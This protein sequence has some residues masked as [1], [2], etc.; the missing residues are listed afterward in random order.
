MEDNDGNVMFAIIWI[1]VIFARIFV[2]GN[3]DEIGVS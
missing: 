1:F 3:L 2:V